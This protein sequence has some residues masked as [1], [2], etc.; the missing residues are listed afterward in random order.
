V[1]L[2]SL[3]T[4]HDSRYLYTGF[5]A[6]ANG[7][8]TLPID[9]LE[10]RIRMA[11]QDYVA[12]QQ[13]KYML[14]ERTA[15]YQKIPSYII[16]E[17]SSYGLFEKTKANGNAVHLTH[18]GKRLLDLLLKRQGIEVRIQLAA[19]YLSTFIK[20][21][22]FLRRLWELPDQPGLQLPEVNYAALD[23]LK[24]GGAEQLSLVLRHVADDIAEVFGKGGAITF[25]PDQFV[26]ACLEDLKNHNWKE[27][28]KQKSFQAMRRAVDNYMLNLVFPR[29]EISRP[30][31]DVL[32][33][34]GDSFG[35][36][37]QRRIA[38][39][40]LTWE[41]IYL[42]AWL[43][44]PMRVIEGIASDDLLKVPVGKA[45]LHVHEPRWDSIRQR[46]L[47]ALRDAYG[48]LKMPV[49]YARVADVRGDV[50]FKLRLAS[51]TFDDFVKRLSEESQSVL[52]FSTSPER[53][54]IKS[55]PLYLTEG[56]TYNLIRVL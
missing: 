34:R 27:E 38:G 28:A 17:L 39:R 14:A 41:H 18:E 35:L 36:V 3:P 53:Y 56:R 42:T 40:R 19:Y 13:R 16:G 54:T 46:F 1:S 49:G 47:Y 55:L 50:C 22:Y 6:F 51:R 4:F 37:N 29:Q 2:K 9:D 48:R 7:P 12:G 10:R 31:Y 32:R 23:P 11:I 33:N 20:A 43:I 15:V 8:E 24:Q 21:D 44:P 25:S 30:K 5:L 26:I 45:I 52:V